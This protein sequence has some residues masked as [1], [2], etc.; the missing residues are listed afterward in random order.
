MFK[1]GDKIKFV[2][3]WQGSVFCDGNVHTVI[4]VS[5]ND[6]SFFRLDNGNT[7]YY[8]DAML[9]RATKGEVL[10]C[11]WGKVVQSVKRWWHT[12]NFN[13]YDGLE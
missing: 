5:P 11:M 8:A 7:S 4:G 2:E 6:K 3:E 12:L 10:G 1:V 9:R 13:N